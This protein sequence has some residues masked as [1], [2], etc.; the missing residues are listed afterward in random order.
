M[1]R[2]GKKASEEFLSA[3]FAPLG[4]IVMPGCEEMGAKVNQWL[5][6]WR[7]RR[8]AMEGTN[9]PLHGILGADRE[10]FLID[11]VLPRFSTGEGKGMI[12]STVRGYDI[13]IISDIGAYDVTFNMYGKPTRMS[14]DDH[15]QDLKRIIAAV[16]GR[17]KRVNIIMP[18]LYEARQHRRTNRESLDCALALQELQN[19]G[20]TNIVTFDAHDPAR[21]ERRAADR[22]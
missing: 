8:D 22:L 11:V 3:P 7:E 4:L 10:N 6:G 5:M 15:Y 12:K 17:A 14:P 13:F 18:M 16:G 20:V 2:N 19:M 1:S 9:T 21:A